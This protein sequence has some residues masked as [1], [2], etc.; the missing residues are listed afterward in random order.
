[1]PAP[2]AFRL[3]PLLL[4]ATA[5]TGGALLAWAGFSG[6]EPSD[7]WCRAGWCGPVAPTA[8]EEPLNPF[9][10]CD[11]AEAAEARGDAAAAEAAWK[12]AVALGPNIPPVLIRRVNSAVERGQI[13]AVLR[14]FRHVLTLTNAYDSILFRYLTRSGLPLERL[15]ADALPPPAPPGSGA[16]VRRTGHASAPDP[17]ERPGGDPARAWVSYLI[18]ARSPDAAAAWKWLEAANGAT[19]E[20][21]AQ[22]VEFLVSDAKAY[23]EAVAAWAGGEPEG[24]PE[25]NRLSNPRFLRALGGGRM[26]WTSAP[27]EQV[28]VTRGTTGITL[29]FSGK[30]NIAYSHL[31][32]QTYLPE[33]RWRLAAEAS[34]EGLTTDQRPYL[35]LYEMYRPERLDVKTP[36]APD[37][38]LVEFRVPPGGSWVIVNVERARSEKFD[39]KLAGRLT[40]REVRLTRA[41][42]KP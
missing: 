35:R 40:L 11:L 8:A 18:G 34:A 21:R 27:R 33:G 7:A 42:G 10:W 30:E 31:S 22:W 16:T 1:M 25:P 37:P 12:R 39:N 17:T 28:S 20:L 13:D 36:M 15:H 23:P 2:S 19:P 3:I 9:A 26:N 14:T 6:L 41:D 38:M 24:Y 4:A 5:A 29:Q 32:Q